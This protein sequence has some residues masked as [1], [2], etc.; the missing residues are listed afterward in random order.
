MGTVMGV[1][2]ALMLIGVVAWGGGH[3][4]MGGHENGGHAEEST[5]KE[6]AKDPCQPPDCVAEKL[7][8]DVNPDNAEDK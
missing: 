8:E 3:G 5:I 4:M 6:D 2:L 1:M 7:K